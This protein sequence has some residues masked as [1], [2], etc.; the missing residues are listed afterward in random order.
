[1][2]RTLWI[3]AGLGCVSLATACLDPA[4]A[5]TQIPQIDGGWQPVAGN[6]DLGQYTSDKQQPVDFAIW[7]AADGT[8]Q[9][10][11]CIRGTRC[12]GQTRL[13][14][15]WEGK[16]F[17]DAHWRPMGIA[18]QADTALGETE[19]GLQAPYV[20][21]AQGRYYMVYGDW[22]RI[23]LAMSPDGKA[24]TRV[25]NEHGQPDLFS[26]PYENT[27]DPMVLTLGNLYYC[28]YMGHKKGAPYQSAVFCRTSDD[29]KHWSEPMMVSA[30]GEAATQTGWFGGDAECPFVVRRD[31]VFYLFRTQRYGQNNVTTLYASRNPW[32]F[33]IG[34]DRYRL[35]TLAVAAP[36]II[37][38]NGQWYIA[39]LNPSLDGIRLAR[40]RWTAAGTGS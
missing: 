10:W 12:G 3:L 17:T 29:L 36:E 33:G 19:G 23:C 24:F 14:H 8:W 30:G 32:C 1:M 28:Y 31:G 39:A 20:F 22:R 11:S 2:C 40:L 6:P 16:R 18:M 21:K 7:Q 4:L 5:A 15:R 35:G 26:G 13:F 34:D 38:H 37:C 27:R 25:L 9:L